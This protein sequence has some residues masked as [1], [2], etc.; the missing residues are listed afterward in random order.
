M[1][2][3]PLEQLRDDMKGMAK[4]LAAKEKDLGNRIAK[5][6]FLVGA[7]TDPGKIQEMSDWET[8]LIRYQHLYLA[9]RT[10]LEQGGILIWDKED[11]GFMYITK[12]EEKTVKLVQQV[13]DRGGV[14]VN[15]TSLDASGPVAEAAAEPL[16]I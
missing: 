8:V 16:L 7:E 2:K 13:E 9:A 15:F 1:A 10:I 11:V 14:V 5:G 6:K 4:A 12:V 3:T